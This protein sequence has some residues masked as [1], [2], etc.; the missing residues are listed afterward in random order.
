MKKKVK[1]FENKLKME[2]NL[3][4]Q[5]NRNIGSKNLYGSSLENNKECEEENKNSN[6]AA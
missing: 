5:E 2:Q 1:E 4:I 3:N 6:A